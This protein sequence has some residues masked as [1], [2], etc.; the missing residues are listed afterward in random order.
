MRRSARTTGTGA[1]ERHRPSAD[2]RRQPAV[3]GAGRQRQQRNDDADRECERL[4][5]VGDGA[6]RIAQHGGRFATLSDPRA[7]GSPPAAHSLRGAD[8]GRTHGFSQRAPHGGS[9]SCCFLCAVDRRPRRSSRSWRSGVVFGSRRMARP[10]VSKPLRTAA[11]T[12]TDTGSTFR[13]SA[14]TA[15]AIIFK[16]ATSNCKPIGKKLFDDLP[17]R[18]R[19]GSFPGPAGAQFSF[20]ECLMRFALRN[21]LSA[22]EFVAVVVSAFA[23]PAFADGAFVT[24][25]TKGAFFGRSRSSPITAQSQS[26]SPPRGGVTQPTPETTMPA[27]AEI[28][29]DAG[30]GT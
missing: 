23:Q 21:H 20:R 15:P 24:Q 28:C 17:G 19:R 16:A 9:G 12:S 27:T 4:E 18:I 26:S 29:R 25:A 14:R 13:R 30:D 1:S 8:A 22:I 10:S 7:A 6:V 11:K 3:H 2:D 5:R